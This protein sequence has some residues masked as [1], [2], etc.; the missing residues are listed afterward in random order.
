MKFLEPIRSGLGYHDYV[1]SAESP[2][3]TESYDVSGSYTADFTNGLFYVL[4]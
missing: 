2:F 4:G 3:G 1:L